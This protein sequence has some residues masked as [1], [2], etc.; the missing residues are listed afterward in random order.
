[1]HLEFRNP[2]RNRSPPDTGGSVGA[3]GGKASADQG[4]RPIASANGLATKGRLR[5]GPE[6]AQVESTIRRKAIFG[7]V[8]ARRR[9]VCFSVRKAGS[10]PPPG[11]SSAVARERAVRADPSSRDHPPTKSAFDI[12][13]L[14]AFITLDFSRCQSRSLEVARLSC[15]CL[16]LARPTFSLARPFF[17]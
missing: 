16:P 8:A 3:G 15:S 13:R 4:K 9:L 14:A 5:S 10:D 2:R 1:M 7:K 11:Y 12:Y 6:G 17:Q